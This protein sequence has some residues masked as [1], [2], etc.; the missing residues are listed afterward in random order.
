MNKTFSIVR[1]ISIKRK[2]KRRVKE[3]KNP[4]LPKRK[5]L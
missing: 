2:N 4:S 3:R 5:G 1:I